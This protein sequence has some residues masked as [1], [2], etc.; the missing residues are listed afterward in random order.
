MK[1]GVVL[2]DA[3]F[4]SS[5]SEGGEF[6]KFYAEPNLLFEN[7]SR[8]SAVS[9][10]QGNSGA[11]ESSL[12][13]A[14]SREPFSPIVQF[15]DVSSR[16]P[17]FTEHVEVSRG[18]AFGDIDKDGDIDMVVSGLDNRLRLF[19]NDVSFPQH[20]WLSVQAITQGRAA[21]GAQVTLQTDSHTL[22]GYV[23]AGTSYLSSCEPNV[24]FGLGTIDA[25]D[26]IEVHW[27]DGSR[28]RFPGATVNQRVKVYQGK[29]V[30]F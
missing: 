11:S 18:M 17:D 19:R 20:H 9:H 22:T 14:E 6:W 13:R 8:R 27:Q 16:A 25:I 2:E 24:H 3:P 30:P 1:R 21:L 5:A 29:G 7:S 10:Q 26:A 28:E 12:P 23:L 4:I 15:S